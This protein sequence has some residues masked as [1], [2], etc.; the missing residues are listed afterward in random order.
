VEYSEEF[1]LGYWWYQWNILKRVIFDNLDYSAPGLLEVVRDRVEYF[2]D[3]VENADPPSDVLRTQLSRELVLLS[4][5]HLRHD[6]FEEALAI[7]QRELEIYRALNNEGNV[8]SSLNNLGGTLIRMTMYEEALNVLQ[9]ALAIDQ[10]IYGAE[11]RE[12]VSTLN[13]MSGAQMHLD[14]LQEARTTAERALRI[15]ENHFYEEDPALYAHILHQNGLVLFQI[16]GA[17]NLNRALTLLEQSIAIQI[18][19][20]G[21]ADG[22]TVSLLAKIER[23]RR[24]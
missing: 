3:L 8:A 21:I 16:G 12:V 15:M 19:L 14:R 22:N 13:T 4:T 7:Q 20:F 2:E 5:I 1:H 9:E 10:R 11:S 17:V 23:K 6:R 24:E 18:R